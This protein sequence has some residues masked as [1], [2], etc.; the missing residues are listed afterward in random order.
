[1]NITDQLDTQLRATNVV[2]LSMRRASVG[3]PPS[4]KLFLGMEPTP[5]DLRHNRAQLDGLRKLEDYCMMPKQRTK[6][7]SSSNLGS[8]VY[9]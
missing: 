4:L 8:P 1:M 2:K 3:T 7:I 9:L 5:R 6:S